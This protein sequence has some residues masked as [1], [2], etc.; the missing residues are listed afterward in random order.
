MKD[1][2]GRTIDYMRISITDRCNLWCKY[3]MPDGISQV[4]MDNILTYEEILLV[5][6]AAAKAGI[7]KF[8]ITGGEPL[9]RLGC[10]GLVGKLKN[11][12]GVEQVTMTTNGV[13]LGKYLPELLENGLD[14]VNISLDTL[15]PGIYQAITG[16]DALKT[17]LESI[18]TALEAGLRVKVNT[19]LQRGVN[20][21]EW[22]EL[23][24]LT[25]DRHLDVRFIE[26]MPIGCGKEYETIYNEELLDKLKTQYPNM[27]E[28]KQ[29]HGNGPAV[30]YRIPEAKG[31]IGFISAMHGKFCGSCNRIRLTSQGRVKPCLCFG[32][33]VDLR[34]ILRRGAREDLRNPEEIK[35][36]LTEAIIRS[37]GMKPESHRFET[38][39]EVT[40][41]KKMVQI[42]G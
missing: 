34:E 33:D 19:V 29:I 13:L 25:I 42:G 20:D 9:V 23:A 8:K 35:V 31:S 32:E 37:V 22:K 40:E 36:Q 15:K 38:I 24:E 27:S 21:T 3:C 16:R 2:Y 30:Y 26:M 5:C 6:Q 10:V 4:P 41:Q 39:N 7:R 14:A 28:D 12:P 17:V 18:E 11:I 1:S